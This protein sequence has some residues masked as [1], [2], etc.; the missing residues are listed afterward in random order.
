MKESQERAETHLNEFTENTKQEFRI[1]FE[2]IEN[3][4]T[5]FP[6]VIS[7]QV[8]LVEQMKDQIDEKAKAQFSQICESMKADSNRLIGIE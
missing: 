7:Q 8:L 3:R 2:R 4:L 5:K 6:E 1:K